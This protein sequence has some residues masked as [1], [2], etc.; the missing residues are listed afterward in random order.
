MLQYFSRGKHTK[1]HIK[2]LLI[3]EK[4]SNRLDE[5]MTTGCYNGGIL[6]FIDLYWIPNSHMIPKLIFQRN[7]FL[8]DISRLGTR[9]E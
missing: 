8:V 5:G 9:K 1:V 6:G 2:W 3:Q 7:F 4:P